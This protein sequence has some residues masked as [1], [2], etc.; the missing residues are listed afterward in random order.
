MKV[1]SINFVKSAADYKG[2]PAQTLPTIAFAGRS[3]VGKSTLL[4]TILNRKNLAKKS[5]KPGK[6]RLLN[7]FLL[8]E[9]IHLVDL[10]GYGYATVSKKI[11]QGWG[12][13]V[14]DFFLNCENLKL[15][16]I[17][18]DVR[19]GLKEM[20]VQLIEWL[21]H[22]EI[23]YTIILNKSDKVS[24]NESSK[25]V[26]ETKT[27]LYLLNPPILFSTLKKRGISETWKTIENYLS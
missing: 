23:N 13:M 14:E 7:F 4:N 2:A 3:N 5:S 26:R 24:N 16:V 18:I 1:N 10:P 20:D 8:N 11:S 22:Q 9:K 15:V 27:L 12:K 21:E 19:R 6:T 25:V 17:I